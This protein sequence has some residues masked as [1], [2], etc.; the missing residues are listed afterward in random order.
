MVNRTKY[1]QFRQMSKREPT[2]TYMPLKRGKLEL[3]DISKGKIVTFNANI[4]Q[5]CV[6]HF[7]WLIN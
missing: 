2:W 1:F 4:K 3:K 5:T 6:E 7:V